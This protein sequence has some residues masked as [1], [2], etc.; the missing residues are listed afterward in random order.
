MRSRKITLVAFMLVAVLMLG[1]GYAALTDTLTI[2]GNAHIDFV[3]TE[4]IFEGSIKFTAADPISSTGAGSTADVASF[5][6]D[7]ATFTANRLAGQGEYSVFKFTVQNEYEADIKLVVNATKL[8][9]AANP[10]NSNEDMFEIT[11]EYSDPDKVIA[12]DGTM[13]ITITV[14]V[15]NPVTANSSAT[16]GVEYTAEPAA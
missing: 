7:D 2:I 10:S 15:K 4:E 8:S 13:D 6:D 16:F 3:K 5:T 11:Y 12:K 9:G 1:I 14:K